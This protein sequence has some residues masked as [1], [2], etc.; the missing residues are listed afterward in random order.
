MDAN[1]FYEN[2]DL[3]LSKLNSGIELIEAQ[4]TDEFDTDINYSEVLDSLYR[5][6][7]QI[8]ARQNLHKFYKMSKETFIKNAE[9]GENKKVEITHTVK[10]YETVISIAQKYNIT[11]EEILQKNNLTSSGITAGVEIQI[12]VNEKEDTVQTYEDIPTFGTQEGDYI[13]GMDA[14]NNLDADSDGDIKIL[15]PVDTFMQGVNNRMKTKNGDYPLEISFGLDSLVGSELPAALLDNLAM[16]KI[17]SQLA[18][19]KRIKSIN[20]LSSNKSENSIKYSI[21]VTAIN[22]KTL[23]I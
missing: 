9:S 3:A 13:L 8:V 19:D 7:K 4:V 20:S 16:V 10:D 23:D 14:A 5:Y 17:V 2:L 1:T 22:N 21:N 15:E 12:D 6:K 11:V 18:L